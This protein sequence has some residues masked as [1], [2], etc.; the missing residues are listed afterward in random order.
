MIGDNTDFG[1]ALNMTLPLYFFLA[2]AETK[3]WVRNAWGVM[4]LITIPAIFFT[5][6]RGAL[7]G[8]AAVFLV[9]DA[10]VEAAF[11]AGACRDPRPSWWRWLCPRGVAKP[12]G[13]YQG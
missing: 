2:Q 11:L 7:V 10:A 8:L 4:F 9:H 12:N 6:S 1:L 13:F 5:Y 3:R